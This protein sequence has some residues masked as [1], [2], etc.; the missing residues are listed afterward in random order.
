[1]A[2]GVGGRG[3]RQGAALSRECVS[4]DG[5]GKWVVKNRQE[6]ALDVG[7]RSFGF[8]C[9]PREKITK[10]SLKSYRS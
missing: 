4:T 7:L 5:I 2:C 10:I 9:R 3:S 8:F 6:E 1:M